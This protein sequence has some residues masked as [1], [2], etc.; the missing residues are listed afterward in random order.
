V[1]TIGGWLWTAATVA[2]R[3]WLA[4]SP[5]PLRTTR[6]ARSGLTIGM[7]L[8]SI[9]PSR[10]ICSAERF[11][12]V[13]PGDLGHQRD[14]LVKRPAYDRPD[15]PSLA[16]LAPDRGCEHQ[17]GVER[18]DRLPAWRARPDTGDA[19]LPNSVITGRV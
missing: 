11:G 12:T 2:I 18:M 1:R 10:T 13:A 5:L 19:N 6:S 8:Q 15:E 14:R 3:F 7:R 16:L 9:A 17:L 4:F